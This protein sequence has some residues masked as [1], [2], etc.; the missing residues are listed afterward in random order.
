M[1]LGAVLDRLRRRRAARR[2][3][4]GE[5]MRLYPVAAAAARTPA[6]YEAYGVPDSFDGRFDALVVMLFL[7]L[8]RVER[9]AALAGEEA[10]ELRRLLLELAVAD[11]DRS[12]REAGVGDLGV[13]RHIKRMMTAALGR[14]TA[15]RDACGAGP[16]REDEA[17]LAAALARNV[18]RRETVDGKA[19]A[20][21]AWTIAARRRLEAHPLSALTQEL[22]WGDGP[23]GGTDG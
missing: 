5:A 17:A 12:L 10:D 1:G 14:M 23:A 11:W 2:R 3:W 7:L 19:R 15:Y 8:D 9:E 16:G 4:R 6:L 20:L 13:G 18:W 22:L 21:A